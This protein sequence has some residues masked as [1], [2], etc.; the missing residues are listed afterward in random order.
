M[1]ELLHAVLAE[2]AMLCVDVLARDRF[3]CAAEFS[4]IDGLDLVQVAL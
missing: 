3:T 1:V 2:A 4:V